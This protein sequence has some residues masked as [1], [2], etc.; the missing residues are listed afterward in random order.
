MSLD[1][2][3][4]PT[5]PLHKPSIQAAEERQEQLTKPPGSLGQLESIA[6]RLAGM[7]QSDRPS[8]E[9]AQITIFAADHGVVAEGVSAFPQ[10]VTLEMV[11]NFSHGGAAICV[12][13][14][15]LNAKMEIVNLGTVENDNTLD[16][17]H[18][19]PLGQGT[20]NFTKQAAMTS[21]QLAQA[22]EAGQQAVECT[23]ET[24]TQIFI[25]GEMGIGNTT[26][27]STLACA[28]TGIP[29]NQ[30]AGP[31]TGLNQEGI[32]HKVEVIQ[33]ALTLHQ[34]HLDEP[35]EALRRLGGFEIAALVG[36]YITCAIKGL[37][38]LVDGFITSVA[39]LI[40]T[41][42]NPGTKDWL[43]FAHQSAEPGH[44]LVLEALEAT[45]LLDISMRLGEGSGAAITLPLLRLACALHN[46]MA[47]FTE[48]GVSG[49]DA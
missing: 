36:S 30:L 40:A 20:A 26:A 8:L 48:A 24:G 41:Q 42:I 35:L 25:G 12:L 29:A 37:P 11:R 38:V 33:R 10:S 18:N 46:N 44:L 22:L 21:E 28:I 13:A 16:N 39:A 32:S 4:H 1:W 34:D 23:M 2:I 45:P 31:G 47:T 43:I 5:K 19:Q 3:T 7:Q 27:A 49:K 9:Q 6:I 15:Q 14:Q 17:I